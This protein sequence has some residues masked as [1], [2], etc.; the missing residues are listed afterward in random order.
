M[1]IFGFGINPD[2][3]YISDKA[4]ANDLGVQYGI[5]II[6]EQAFNDALKMY[7]HG[8][9]VPNYTGGY[10]EIEDATFGELI[11]RG[12]YRSIEL[13]KQLFNNYRNGDYRLN[14]EELD[15]TMV[16]LWNKLHS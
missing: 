8:S 13:A 3:Q 7:R 2:I 16:A 5:G 11:K 9:L 6:T 10:C 1:G 4:I 14:K 12:Q 15:D